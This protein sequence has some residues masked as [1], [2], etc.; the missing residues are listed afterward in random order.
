MKR[1]FAVI[2]CLLTLAF[3]GLHAQNLV[4]DNNA[5]IRQVGSFTG[6]YVSGGISVYVS[7]GTTQA[8][9]VSASEKKYNGKIRTE[10]QGGVL[11]I[12]VEAGMWN[13]FN[14]GNKKIK[15]Y[16]TVTDLNKLTLAGGSIVRLTDPLKVNTLAVAISGGSIFNGIMSGTQL[17]MELHGGSICN[18]DGS[19]T[20]VKFE[21]TGGS[22][23]NGC[24]TTTDNCELQASG[25]SIAHV[26]VSKQM[27][28]N[29]SG[30]SII[31]YSGDGMMK[32]VNTSGGSIVKKTD[33]SNKKQS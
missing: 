20:S 9:A 13:N 5:E 21:T 3:T 4:N 16:V 26:R 6:L 30:G 12:Y 2:L 1:A 7:Q 27:T 10:V 18:I 32:E 11:K 25:G 33:C 29:A 31:N 19:F 23:L 24:N 8:I 14:I 17:E 28:V 22:I 15:A